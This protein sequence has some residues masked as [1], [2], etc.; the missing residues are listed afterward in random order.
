MKVGSDQSCLCRMRIASISLS[1]PSA[2]PR[3]TS[4]AVGM[5]KGRQEV[6]PGGEGDGLSDSPWMPS[7]STPASIK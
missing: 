6:V 1:M 4:S 2:R 5:G 3:T 7:M